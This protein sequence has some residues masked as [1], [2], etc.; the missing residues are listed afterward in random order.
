MTAPALRP[1]ASPI[2]LLITFVGGNG[3]VRFDADP[4]PLPDTREGVAERF[5]AAARSLQWIAGTIYDETGRPLGRRVLLDPTAI[6][7]V[8]SPRDPTTSGGRTR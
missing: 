4:I 3:P 5:A 8:E 2:R 1:R 7:L 6:A